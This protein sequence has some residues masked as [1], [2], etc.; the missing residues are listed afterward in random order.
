MASKRE[1]QLTQA[2]TDRGFAPRVS[3]AI[4]RNWFG[5]KSRQGYTRP[6]S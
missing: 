2:V 4:F 5:A 1:S 6:G 3:G